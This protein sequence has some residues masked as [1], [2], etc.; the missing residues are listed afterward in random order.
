MST[1][2]TKSFWGN[3]LI[4][5][6]SVSYQKRTC[7]SDVISLSIFSL[8]ILKGEGKQSPIFIYLLYRTNV[9]LLC[10]DIHRSQV[11]TKGN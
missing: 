5:E 4:F 10:C 9:F 8:S 7:S 2:F 6:L 1:T 3:I 11:H